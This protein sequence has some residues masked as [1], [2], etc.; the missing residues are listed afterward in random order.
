MTL[1]QLTS[2]LVCVA[3]SVVTDSDAINQKTKLKWHKQYDV[4][5]KA[6]QLKAR[7]LVVVLENPQEK[8][9]KIDETK[10]Q[11]RTR[12]TIAKQKF[13]LVRVDVNTDYG[14]RVA[15]AFG[16]KKFPYTAVTDK[17]SVH[18]VYRKAGQMSAN[19]WTMAL[20]KSVG[21][22]IVGSKT[23]VR[24]P[25]ADETSVVASSGS[26]TKLDSS[27]VE[28]KKVQQPHPVAEKSK[29]Q[30][31]SK[32]TNKVA[33]TS[34]STS[35][36]T[37]RRA[38]LPTVKW[39]SSYEAASAE[40]AKTGRPMFVFLTAPACTYCEILKKE[41]LTQQR[42]IDELNTQYIPVLVNGRE[43][44]EI[45]DRYAVKMFPT[46]AIVNPNGDILELWS[47]YQTAEQFG[48]HLT[49][50]KSKLQ[51]VVLH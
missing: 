46:L 41:A 31:V 47:G 3:A 9:Q 48:A 23:F 30:S 42:F 37:T 7:P 18:I 15:A 33:S 5:K 43:R 25:V 12:A 34:P 13:E 14:K 1:V 22:K 51:G 28:S 44:K 24:K 40:M 4:A 19:D 26:A 10:L 17:K 11:N 29:A 27:S 38:G 16:A 50:A 8:T 35:S 39:A 21:S 20:A 2:I 36:S 32:A 6:A 45:A 49:S